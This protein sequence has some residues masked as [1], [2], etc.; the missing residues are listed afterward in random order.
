MVRVPSVADEDAR[1]LYRTWE[2]LQGVEQKQ[3]EAT[4][5][6]TV[7]FFNESTPPRSRDDLASPQ[8]ARE[9][10][11]GPPIRIAQEIEGDLV[12]ALI[13]RLARVV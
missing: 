2:T 7:A 6:L 4:V 13:E 3:R 12:E 11:G 8:C 1:Q 5:S 9:I 10:H